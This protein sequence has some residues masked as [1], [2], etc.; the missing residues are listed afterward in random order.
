MENKGFL[1]PYVEEEEYLFGKLKPETLQEDGQ[2]DNFLP[3][4]EPQKKN[5]ETSNCTGF[6]T[7]SIIEM[8]LKRKYGEVKNFSDRALGIVAGTYPPGNT[9]SKVAEAAR[10]KG[11]IEE[12]YLPFINDITNVDAYYSPNPLPAHLLRKMKQFLAV[13]DIGHE[14]VFT[15]FYKPEEKIFNLKETLKHSPVGVSV[16]AWFE[17]GKYY[18][19]PPGARDNHFTILY[20][21]ED[22]KYWKIFDSYKNE[23]KKLYWNYGF[24]FGKSFS[25][26]RKSAD[27][28]WWSWL[29]WWR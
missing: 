5:V 6:T 29:F 14:W 17:D 22:K 27:T 9:P 13:Y 8:L 2:W 24:E 15:P 28:K 23:Y 21:Y 4:F 16:Y 11:L 12:P 18:D 19:K 26:E 1:P 10:K 20:G 7:T 25:I 3:P